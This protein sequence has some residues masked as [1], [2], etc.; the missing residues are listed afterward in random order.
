MTGVSL[1]FH[2]TNSEIVAMAAGWTREFS[3][4]AALGMLFGDHAVAVEDGDFNEALQAVPV[5]DFV[6]LGTGPL[7]L[8]KG[9]DLYQLTGMNSNILVLQ[10]GAQRENGLSESVMAGVGDDPQATGLWRRLVNRA[11]RSM[12]AGAV[13]TDPSRG[14]LTRYPSH[15]FTDGALRLQESGVSMRGPAGH[16]LYRLTADPTPLPLH[17]DDMV[18][19]ATISHAVDQ[20]IQGALLPPELVEN[21][22]EE[23]ARR[24]LVKRANT[25]GEVAATIF[26]VSRR[27]HNAFGRD[28]KPVRRTARTRRT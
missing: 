23:M 5:P 11:R 7:R 28:D 13:I 19:L 21:L 24:K 18:T 15:R 12:H 25:A 22:T 3:L 26:D 1:Q 6:I 8:P 14:R 10:P 20:W 9:A 27:L 4:H 16:Q 17:D 2:A